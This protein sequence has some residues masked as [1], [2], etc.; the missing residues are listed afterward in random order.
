V[1]TLL[2]RL[3][4]DSYYYRLRVTRTNKISKYSFLV[5]LLCI[6]AIRYKCVQRALFSIYFIHLNPGKE[7]FFR[8][9]SYNS[10]INIITLFISYNFLY[11]NFNNFVTSLTIY[12]PGSVCRAYIDVVKSPTHSRDF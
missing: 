7:H 1:F 8:A 5:L 6:N 10:N 3:Q 9:I 11:S 12:Y 4:I 2:L